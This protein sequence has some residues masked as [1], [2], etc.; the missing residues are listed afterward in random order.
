M[1][2]RDAGVPVARSQR[3]QGPHAM[4]ETD[5]NRNST[6]IP[7]RVPKSTR[8]PRE[9][10]RRWWYSG[11]NPTCKSLILSVTCWWGVRDAK[12]VCYHN[13]LV[14]KSTTPRDILATIK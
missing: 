12:C 9:V 2:L 8:I 4:V 7:R 14:Y 10:G 3:P 6:D 11:Q 5:Q 13:T 1:P